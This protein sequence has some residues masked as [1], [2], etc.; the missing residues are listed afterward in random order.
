MLNFEP[1]SISALK[2]AMPYI[3]KNISLNSDISAG[4]LFMWQEGDNPH[5]CFWNDTLVLRNKIGEQPAFTWPMGADVSGMVDMLIRYTQAH[6]LPLRFYE[7][8]DKT[9]DIIKADDRFKSVMYAYEERWSDYIYSFSEMMTFKGNKYKGQRNH[10]NKFKRMYGEPNIRPINSNDIDGIKNMLIKY[11]SEHGDANNLERTEL[12]RAQRLLDIYNDLDLYAACMIVD[13][14]IAAFSIG[15]V[16]GDIL[17]IHIEKALKKFDGAYPTMYR[18]FVNLISEQLGRIPEFVNREDDSGDEGLRISKLQYHPVGRVHKH[19]VHI[20]SPAS[21]LKEIPVINS[22]NVVLTEFRESD[23]ATYLSLNTNIENNRFWGYDYREDDYI[24]GSIDENT[25]YDSAML[26]IKAGDSINFAV[27]TK[28]DGYMIGEAILWNFTADGF[29]EVGCRLLPQHQ[30]K[31][32]GKS[33]FKALSDF[34]EKTLKLKVW[35]RCCIKNT[36]SYRM[37]ISSGYIKSDE[38]KEFYYFKRK[39]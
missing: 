34:A 31:G 32:L 16:I 20:N 10:I 24:T 13:N 3:K 36:V 28:C 37:I 18:G 8:D 14:E 12:I 39:N 2:K 21:K 25:F 38:D 33:A 17:F 22:G 19:L 26:D 4:A 6:H 7:I 27:R 35:A 11:K 29:T 15:E 5:F 30:G 1:F 23:K 9:L